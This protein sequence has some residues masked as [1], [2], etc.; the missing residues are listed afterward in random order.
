MTIEEA[1]TIL[2]DVLGQT[3]LNDTQELVFRHAWDAWTYE[4][5][6]EQFGYTTDHIKNVGAE[7]WGALSALTGIKV[8][9]RNL[10]TVLRRWAEDHCSGAELF[11]PHQGTPHQDWGEAPDS[12]GFTG[13]TQELATLE[14]WIVDER[15][16]LVAL[17]GM[18]GMGKTA[19]AIKLA[20]AVQHR[21]DYVVWRSSFCLM[22]NK[23]KQPCPPI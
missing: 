3:T 15:C 17:L 10:Q 6:A 4:R 9:K 12:T 11:R 20:Q 23:P 16:R 14:R 19:L 18:G 22:G 21:F 13:R 8:T 5:M 2:D 7:L 1:L